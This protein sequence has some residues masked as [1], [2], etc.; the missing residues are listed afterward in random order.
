MLIYNIYLIYSV[1]DKKSIKM[2][3]YNVKSC[4]IIEKL[5]FRILRMPKLL[6]S[7]E[8][9]WWIYETQQD[10]MSG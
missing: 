10:I 1:C 3:Y 2:F 6:N 4:I 7:P 9:K 8:L 5:W